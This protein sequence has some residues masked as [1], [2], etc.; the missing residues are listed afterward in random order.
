MQNRLE[1]GPYLILASQSPRR[2]ELLERAGVDFSVVPSSFDEESIPVTEPEDYVRV[3]AEAKAADIAARHPENWVIGADTIVVIDDVI[4]GKPGTDDDART[5]LHAL[6]NRIHR[7][8]TAYALVHQAKG[9]QASEAVITEVEF[10]ALSDAEVEWY[11]E[12][13]EPFDKAGGYGIQGIGAF[14]VRRI[15]GSYTN[16]VGLPVCEVIDTLLREKVL[17]FSAENGRLLHRP[18][19]DA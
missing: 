16:V 18:T 3:L 10:K 14:L 12:T 11:I 5:M 15:N 7:V 4:L 17:A 2:R 19:A 6:S 1:N 8:I 9:R 13:G